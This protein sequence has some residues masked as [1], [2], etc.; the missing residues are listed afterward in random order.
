MRGQDFKWGRFS[1]EQVVAVGSFENG[2][3][4]LLPLRLQSDQAVVAFSGQIGGKQQSGQLRVENLPVETLTGLVPLPLNV[5]GLLNATATISGSIDNPQ[6]IGSL[7]LA[8]GVLN[9]TPVQEAR[10]SFTYANA[11]LDF[12][13]TLAITEKEPLYIIGSLPLPIAK[14]VP[15]SNQIS[16]DI[17]VKNEGLALLNVLTNQVAWVDGKG[18]VRARVRGT[19]A[20]PVIT[21]IARVEDATLQARA[22]PDPLT[23]VTGVA[24]FDTDRVRVEQ[25]TGSFSRGKVSATGVIPLSNRLTADDPDQQNLLTVAL[26]QIR[27]NLK[28]LYQGG[29]NGDVT[30]TGTALDPVIG[31]LIRLSDGQVLLPEP[32][33][34]ITAQVNG[35]GSPNSAVEFSD[36]QLTLGDRVVITSQPIIS[37]VATGDLI[38]N[39]NLNELRPDGT[40]RLRSGQVNLFTTQFTLERGY[41]QTAVFTPDRK[42]DPELNIRLVALVPEVTSRRQPSILSQ[43]EILDVPAPATSYGSLQTVRVRAEVNGPA[44]RLSENLRLSSSPPRS[45]EEIVALIGGSFVDTLGRGDTLLG[46]A[47]LAGSALLSNIQGFIG[48]ALGLSEFR[49]FPTTTRDDE[50]ARESGDTG[51]LGLAAEAAVDITPALSVSVVKILT[52]NQPPQFGL[53]YRIND[54][55]LLRSSTDFSGDTRA[56]IEYEA[57]F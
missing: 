1:A 53:R 21:G 20:I 8:N 7:S 33:K 34:D 9:G 51:T 29:V 22:L 35:D 54:F 26:N 2:A 3:V 47:N 15:A 45:E 23:N 32:T 30:V 38:I 55:L 46:V 16:L 28:G 50:E 43:S 48:N 17:N 25:L 5:Q 11:R 49:L 52:N 56:V 4:T 27:L 18:E 10:G 6:V 40:I 36:L 41:P 39:G 13:N 57:R 14:A 12:T 44:S 19:F 31:G 37:F 42:L 24:R